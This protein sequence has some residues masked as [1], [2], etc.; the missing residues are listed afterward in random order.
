MCAVLASAA[1]GGRGAHAPKLPPAGAYEHKDGTD[2]GTGLLARASV[3]FTTG[4]FAAEGFAEDPRAKRKDYAGYAYGGLVYGGGAYGGVAY[5]GYS[6]NA[7]FTPVS[8][9]LDYAVQSLADAGAVAGTVTWPKAS[10]DRRLKSPCGEIDNPTLRL[11]AR[12]EVG[13]AV[14]YLDR[15][16]KGR[17]APVASRAIEL[18]GVVEKAPCVLRPAVQVMAPVP[19]PL[20]IY[21]DDARDI[22]V[23]RG[24][25]GEPSVVALGPIGRR[26]IGIGRGI[27]VVADQA[28]RLAPAW[29]VAPGHPY[30]AITDDAGRF[31]IDDIVPGTY[32]LVVW[33][34]PVIT[35]WQDAKVRYGAPVVVTRSIK[36]SAYATA[37]AD[38]VLGGR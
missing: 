33:H 10:G 14:V 12:G 15:I 24:D 7:T 16:E 34:P 19:S 21:N 35:G 30:V 31:R 9:P 28:G 25:T 3:K 27:T 29:I 37:K 11:G 1:C 13:G 2:D 32:Q 23:A 8:R 20:T 38:V 4:D 22:V 26:Q 6:A 5:A 18:G 36:V 17:A